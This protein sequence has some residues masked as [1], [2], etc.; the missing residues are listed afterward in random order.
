MKSRAAT[1][2][3]HLEHLT[4][5]LADPTDLDVAIHTT[6]TGIKRLRAFLR[7]ARQSIGTSTYRTENDA[8]GHT[9]RLLAPARDAYVLIETARELGATDRIVAELSEDHT[10]AI[11]ALEAGSRI[12]A[13]HGLEATTDRWRLLE[14]H[15]PD[16]LSIGAG[17]AR[18]YGRGLSDLETVRTAPASTSFHRWR[19]RVKY[20]R[21]QLE[22]LDA[23][24][25]V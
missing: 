23:P 17:L 19:R 13:V 10:R 22:A 20:L 6:R 21:Y 14:W 5:G 9:A 11:A 8:L 16:S 12:E 25:R 18:T 1:E 15:G 24:D 2:V 7:L 4:A 3:A